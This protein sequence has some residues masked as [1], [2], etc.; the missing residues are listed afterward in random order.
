MGK[1]DKLV[2]SSLTNLGQGGFSGEFARERNLYPAIVVPGGTR[3]DAE[4][5]RIRARIVAINDE[6]GTIMGK[7]SD[8]ST[9]YNT[10]SGADRGIPDDDLVMCIPFLPQFFF[11]KPQV[12]EM[13][14]VILENP[15]DISSVRYWIGP[16]IT[17]KL[18]LRSQSY[19]D[20]VKLFDKTKFYTN[21]KIESSPL[22]I[23]RVFP[24]DSDVAVQGR[25]D[26]DLI[27][28]S[29]EA[30]L[31]AGK[32]NSQTYSINTKT[33]SF[34]N[35]KQINLAPTIPEVQSFPEPTHLIKIIL[36]ETQ[37]A[38]IANIRVVYFDI[39]E[40][41]T[42]EEYTIE[43]ETDTS[44]KRTDSIDF[45]KSKIEEYK[46]KYT[47][48]GFESSDIPEFEG[49]SVLYYSSIPKTAQ[50]IIEPFSQGELVSNVLALYAPN[51]KFRNKDLSS[52]EA[53]DI[54]KKWGVLADSLHPSTFGDETIKLL[55]LIIRYLLNHIHQPQNPPLN[56]AISD[57]LQRYT[58]DGKLQ[59]L[60][61]NNVR[62]N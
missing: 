3:D 46:S 5:N 20:S 32:F 55:D 58:L 12:G 60:L 11:V 34:L 47:L 15:K 43:E 30:L 6:D 26:A 35:L 23:Q 13:V 54:L 28:R 62:I 61:S 2:K 33:P 45:L 10:F 41:D 31:V 14:F 19:E 49:A 7:T 51:G 38:F 42:L 59:N 25:N 18:K 56:T 36:K 53:V 17:S 29:R 24:Q 39:L 4:Q 21:R 48:W 40:D 27:L 9:D 8:N 37:E 16:I 50:E 1:P 52:V 44:K 22:D 57:E